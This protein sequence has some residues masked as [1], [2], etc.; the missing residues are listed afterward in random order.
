MAREVHRLSNRAN[1]PFVAVNCAALPENILESELFGSERGAFTGAVSRE[2]RFER[3]SGG[4]MLLDE[5][6]TSRRP[7]R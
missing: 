3:A 7:H 1:K 4:T 2:G 5:I 6:G